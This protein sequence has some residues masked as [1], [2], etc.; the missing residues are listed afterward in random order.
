MDFPQDVKYTETHEWIN[1]EG[2]VGVSEYAQKEISDVVYVELP[3]EGREVGAGDV[4]CVVESVK[5]AFDIYAP[6]AGT[7]VEVNSSLEGDPALVN[8]SCYGD[9]WLVKIETT[10]ATAQNALLDGA[11]YTS[12]VN[13]KKNG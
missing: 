12:H 9:G 8:T 1:A 4:V 13:T 10:D 7:V 5:A 6:V 11:A 3:E 2:R